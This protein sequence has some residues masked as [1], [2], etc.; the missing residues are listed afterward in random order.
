MVS[1]LAVFLLVCRKSIGS[2]FATFGDTV[3]PYGTGCHIEKLSI[4]RCPALIC[5]LAF[6][7]IKTTFDRIGIEVNAHDTTILPNTLP[8]ITNMSHA[9]MVPSINQS[10]NKNSIAPISPA[11]T[12]SVVRQP[13]QCSAAKSRKHFHTYRMCWIILNDTVLYLY[14][15]LIHQEY[16][17][18]NLTV[19]Q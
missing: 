2:G 17:K 16:S 11:T 14:G 13:N 6:C 8:G 5:C 15:W 4:C 19:N 7:D 1:K 18:T 3:V 12:G 10:I 9:Y